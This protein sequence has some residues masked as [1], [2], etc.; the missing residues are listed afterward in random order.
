MEIRI[1]DRMQSDLCH[2]LCKL[3]LVSEFCRTTRGIRLIKIERRGGSFPLWKSQEMTRVAVLC[4]VFVSQCNV[5]K[6]VIFLRS[7]IDNVTFWS[8]IEDDATVIQFY[9]IF[10]QFFLRSFLFLVCILR[11]WKE[12]MK[13]H[14]RIKTT[15]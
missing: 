11:D 12:N 9:V 7:L 15:K 10:H 1:L 2:V 4:F 6:H 8:A 5:N 3:T 14:W 13:L